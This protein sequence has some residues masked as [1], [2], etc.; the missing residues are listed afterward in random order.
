MKHAR[1]HRRDPDPAPAAAAVPPAWA[2]LLPAAGVAL[3]ALLV[4]LAT[5]APN[6]WWGDGLELAAAANVLGV[7]HPTGYPLYMLVGHVAIRLLAWVEPGRATTILSALAMAAAAGLL[8]PLLGRAAHEAGAARSGAV[9]AGV[10]LLIAFSDTVWSHA[11]FTDVF[12]LTFLLVVAL[13]GV[14]WAPPAATPRPTRAAVLG[15]LL[16][17]ASLNHYSILACYPLVG[18]VVLDWARRRG[19]LSARH[20]A[21]AAAGWAVALMGY[22]Y[23]PLRARANPP[24]N[25]GDPSTLD[26][27][28]WVLTGGQFKIANVQVWQGS[29]LDR[30]GGWLT[31]WG[32]LWFEAPA[33]LAI[34]LGVALLAAALA[35]LVLLARRRPA[36]GL[37]LMLAIAATAV[38]AVGYRIPDIEPYFLPALPAAAIGWM[39]LGQWLLARAR[40]SPGPPLRALPLLLALPV[41]MFNW[42]RIDKSWDHGPTSYGANIMEA[43]PEQAVVITAGDNSI[44]ALWYQQIG[45]GRRPDV[46]VFGSNFMHNGWYARHFEGPGRPSAPIHI[47]ERPVQTLDKVR[48]YDS[49]TENALLPLF[50]AGYRVFATEPD[51]LYVEYF[52]ARPTAVLL[53]PDYIERSADVLL[54]PHPLLYE[55]APNPALA[56]RTR[57]ERLAEI[58]RFF[59]RLDGFNYP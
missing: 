41:V 54:L 38:F 47:H 55:L 29:P 18:L 24:L 25:W 53:S 35:G 52:S 33:P 13:L 22:L 50:A 14:A 9:A 10:A 51:P 39:Q 45:L 11:T 19:R 32:S 12:P 23:L 21:A 1:P 7:P 44:F 48:Y 46:V 2:V 6:P 28:L 26:R 34:A 4:Y 8:A 42:G 16:G 3:A 58:R 36:L 20:L 56:A 5:A 57:A 30:F 15:A 31:W 37:G 49:L 17:I 59:S 43:L 40:L 27:L